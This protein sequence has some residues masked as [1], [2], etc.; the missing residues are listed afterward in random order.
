V[1]DQSEEEDVEREEEARDEDEQEESAKAESDSDSSDESDAD[2]SE[3]KPPEP[4]EE[5]EEEE[6]AEPDNQDAIVAL[7]D[8]G[9]RVDS[10]DKERVWRVFFYEKHGD[11]ALAQVHGLP[12]L[13]EV[14]ILG[15][16]IT[17]Q[18]KDRFVEQFPKVKVYYG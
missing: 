6:P 9:A 12:A 7:K 1:A 15:T 3:E 16:K 17:E 18:M 2:S 14:W 5:E 8:I 11:D 10:N 4:V 13:K